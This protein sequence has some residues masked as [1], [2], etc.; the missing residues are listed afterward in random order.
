MTESFDPYRKWLGIPEQ[1]RPPNHYRLLGI[2][3][4]ESDTDVISNAADGRMAQLKNYQAGKYSAYSQRLLN[5]IATAKVCLLHP[6]RKIE[7]DRQLKLRGEGKEGEQQNEEIMEIAGISSFTPARTSSYSH[8]TSRKQSR[9]LMP[10]IMTG[11]AIL[12]IVFLAFATRED[13]NDIAVKQMAPSNPVQTQLDASAPMKPDVPKPATASEKP[14]SAPEEKKP[15]KPAKDP[16][17][18]QLTMKDP[19]PPAEEPAVEPPAEKLSAPESEPADKKPKKLPVPDEAKQQA[20]EAKIREIF[21]KEIAAA[22]AADQKLNL[23]AKLV[24]Q[25][26]ETA[27]DPDARFVS[28]LR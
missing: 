5:E 19:E 26:S 12:F 21:G 18:A 9:W 24:K 15:E 27:D 8:R 2:E 14:L 22:K 6:S 11:G 25:G 7:Y 17:P 4:F 16:E 20:A 3:L 1:E 13:A 10:L 28:T 23:A